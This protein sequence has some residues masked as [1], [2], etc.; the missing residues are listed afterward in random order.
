[1]KEP[2]FTPNSA[3][4]IKN[5]TSARKTPATTRKTIVIGFPRDLSSPNPRKAIPKQIRIKIRV[6]C[7]TGPEEL[8]ERSMRK[9]ALNPVTAP[10]SGVLRA[11]QTNA[12]IR[13]IE[14]PP[15][16]NRT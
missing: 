13:N 16:G 15:P 7:P 8:G 10:T 3:P 4:V 6:H 1:V 11:D 9:P 14:K 2:R 12:K 5:K